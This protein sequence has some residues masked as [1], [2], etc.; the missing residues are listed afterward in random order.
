MHG[1]RESLRIRA[2][3]A[4]GA[5]LAFYAIDHIGGG[6]EGM[7]YRRFNDSEGRAWEAW[8]VHPAI[9]ER[10]VN[11]ER[12]IGGRDTAERRQTGEFRLVIPT[13]LQGGWL[14]LQAQSTKLRVSPI[15]DGWMHLSDDELRV[16]VE[17]SA[18]GPH[19]H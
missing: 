12:R 15:P 19:S 2:R 14:A 13:E 8:E 16:L 11:T 18:T 9:V 3:S 6:T 1:G 17:R 7:A 5:C 4:S 10:R